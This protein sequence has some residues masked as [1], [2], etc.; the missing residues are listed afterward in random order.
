MKVVGSSAKRPSCTR[1]SAAKVDTVPDIIDEVLEEEKL[2]P[3]SPAN[4]PKEGLLDPVPAFN[5]EEVIASVPVSKP[6]TARKASVK[7]SVGKVAEPKA[8]SP[9]KLS[10]VKSKSPAKASTKKEARK[11]SVKKDK[12]EAPKQHSVKKLPSVKKENVK[13]DAEPV[14]AEVNVVEEVKRESPKKGGA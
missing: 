6:A 12:A 2:T 4:S 7:K 8:V 13:K 3:R 5:I 9:E 11:E 14:A 10:P 1:K